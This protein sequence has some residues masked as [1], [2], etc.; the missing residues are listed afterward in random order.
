MP[1]A[2]FVL[3]ILAIVASVPITAILTYH[4]RKMAEIIH[5]SGE[6]QLAGEIANLRGD[7]A[8]LKQL[9]HQQMI[10]LDSSTNSSRPPVEVPLQKRLEQI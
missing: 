5:R 7:I 2:F 1:D 3:G 4:Q 6:P 9:V 8:Q 10:A